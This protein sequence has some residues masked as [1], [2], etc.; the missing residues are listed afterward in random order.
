[1]EKEI[2][3]FLLQKHLAGTLTESEKNELA[4]Y[5]DRKQSREVT[6]SVIEELLV[7][8]NSTNQIDNKTLMPVVAAI[9]EADANGVDES[10]V[11]VK[12]LV[13]KRSSSNK[14]WMATIV[15]LIVAAAALYFFY[16]HESS[17]GERIGANAPLVNDAAPGWNKAVLT[18]SDGSEFFLD[19]VKDGF[20]I[21][22]GNV[23][24]YKEAKGIL[25]YKGSSEMNEAILFN[26]V[27]TPRGGQYE[28]KLSD[29]SRVKLNSFSS[30]T[31]PVWF[32]GNE[33]TV[34][35]TGEA[36]FEVAEN[37]KVP[38]KINAYDVQVEV[39]GTEFNINAY[40]DEP[41]IETTLLKGGVDVSK[42]DATHS[43][44]PLQQGRFDKEGNFSLQ[45]NANIKEVIAWRNGLFQFNGENLKSVLR[46]LSRWYDVDIIYEP[47]SPVNKE[48]TGEIRRNVKLSE[49]V[50]ML[51]KNDVR[52]I[53]EGKA[54][55]VLP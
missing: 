26:T 31:Y 10:A 4:T 16:F 51:Q 30:I 12:K 2:L 23:K 15:L 37:A 29:G 1:M 32:T 19:S 52:C 35:V 48:I 40:S 7:Q 47:R 22:Q 53:I 24:V 17:F 45:K 25:T 13:N 18:V 28:I 33:R 34:T 38:F 55:I 14:A 46:Q 21:Q 50:K 8:H 11:P 41:V 3:I 42:N 43:L 20:V 36:Y 49:V 39:K 5:L 44:Q 6:T 54:L 9:L 27:M